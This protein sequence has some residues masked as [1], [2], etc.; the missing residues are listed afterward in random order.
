MRAPIPPQPRCK[1]HWLNSETRALLIPIV[2]RVPSDCLVGISQTISDC[3]MLLTRAMLLKLLVRRW[4][5]LLEL[6]SPPEV[7]PGLS[8]RRKFREFRQLR[9]LVMSLVVDK[10]LRSTM[11]LGAT[12][13]RTRLPAANTP[14]NRV[15]QLVNVDWMMDYQCP[16]ITG[17]RLNFK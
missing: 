3:Q 9:D 15:F 10:E 17:S 11:I 4:A 13:M 7:K 8:P 6:P 14:P 12:R 1:A 5:Q 2:I 16:T